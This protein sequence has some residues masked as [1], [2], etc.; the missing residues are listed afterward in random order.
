MSYSGFF[1]AHSVRRW[2]HGIYVAS[3]LVHTAQQVFSVYFGCQRSFYQL[4]AMFCA[5]YWLHKIESFATKSG[6]SNLALQMQNC[7]MNFL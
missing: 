4:F 5:P 3:K 2:M 1:T 7:Q 6:S